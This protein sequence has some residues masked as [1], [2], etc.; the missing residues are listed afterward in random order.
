M[1]YSL[2]GQ[3]VHTATNAVVIECGGVGYY[4]RVT[5]RTATD[6]EGKR[7]RAEAAM[8]FTVMSVS[9]NNVSLFGFVDPEERAA[10]EL[11]GSVSG[12]GGRTA[13]AVLSELTP[14]EFA[15]AV[16]SDDTKT[17]TRAKGIGAK[18]AAR[19][20]LELKDRITKENPDLKTLD[21]MKNAT[22]NVRTAIITGSIAEAISALTVLGFTPQN[23]R[24]ALKDADGSL[25]SAELIKL[26][27]RVLSNK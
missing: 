24:A 13:L 4:A 21:T 6:C 5:P 14:Q 17:I 23:A 12:I 11:L 1:I 25:P 27:L 3:V 20:V 15:L 8:L 26:G 9:E 18:V 10:F 7:L 19:I 16:V 22:G 2:H